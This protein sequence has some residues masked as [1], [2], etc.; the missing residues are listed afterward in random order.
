MRP[1]LLIIALLSALLVQETGAHAQSAPRPTPPSPE[2]ARRVSDRL[3]KLFDQLRNAG[4]SE[5]AKPVV[6]EIERVFER[7][8]SATADLIYSRA[9][10]A[11][12]AKDFELALDLFDYATTLRPGWAEPYHRRAIVHFI[13]KD[14]DAAFR[15]IRET[16]AREPRHFFALAGLGGILKGQG[17]A[18]G[19]FR[20]FSRALELNPH[21]PDLKESIEKMRTEV[22]GQPI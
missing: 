5:A 8:G 10:E 19:A 17:D 12:V 6:T 16:L 18:K 21:F 7:S 11:M 9:K 13:L 2:A 14:Q 1:T 20:A 22:E 15:D 3:D 4:S